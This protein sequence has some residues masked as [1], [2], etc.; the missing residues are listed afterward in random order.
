MLWRRRRG[1][2]IKRVNKDVLP[3]WWKRFAGYERWLADELKRRGIPTYDLYAIAHARA[4]IPKGAI[5]GIDAGGY[6]TGATDES[7]GVVVGVAQESHHALL[8]PLG[9]AKLVKVAIAGRVT[10]RNA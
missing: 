2:R 7:P 9:R 3:W 5:V 10:Y 4:H 1:P 8:S 6:L